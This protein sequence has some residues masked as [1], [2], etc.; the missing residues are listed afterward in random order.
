MN[1]ANL[2]SWNV[3]E[4]ISE[5]LR[6]ILQPVPLLAGLTGAGLLALYLLSFFGVLEPIGWPLLA[7][8]GIVLAM[9]AAH[10]GIVRVARRS[11]GLVAYGLYAMATAAAALGL[12]LVWQGIALVAA[13]LA[14]LAPGT[15]TRA[16]IP[17]NPL[18]AS[19]ALGLVATGAIF[20][21]DAHP[22]L[23]RMQ[24]GTTGG[25]AA[26]LL[27]ASMIAL[28]GLVTITTQAVRYETLQSR[29]VGSLVPIVAIPILF[30]TSISAFNALTTNQQ[31]FGSTLQAVSSLRKGQLDALQHTV[32]LELA[33]LQD[34]ATTASSIVHVI[35]RQNQSDEEYRLN[36][37]IAATQ[38]RD[39]IVTHP[40]SDYEEVMVM[41]L[42]GNVLLSTYLLDV[43]RNFADEAFFTRGVSRQGAVFT[44]FPGGQNPAGDYKLVAAAPVYASGQ[45]DVRGMVA[46]VANG[47]VVLNI[48][49]P[50]PG[51]ANANTYLV[52]ST[53]RPITPMQV[54][55]SLVGTPAIRNAVAQQQGQGSGLYINYAGVPV[56]GFYEWIPS[57][58]AAIVA[59]IP[60]ADLLSR[61][62]GALLASAFVGLLTIIIAVVAITTTSRSISE[63]VSDLAGVAEHLATGHLTTRAV[64]NREDE[65]GQLA[66]SFNSMAAQ[67]QGVI[68]DLERRVAERTR[69]LEQQTVRLRTAAE[70]AR[71]ATIATSLQDLLSRAAEF[72][73]ERFHLDHV[74]IF[75]LDEPKRFAVLQAS[76]TEVGRRMLEA[77]YRTPMGEA[78][79]VGQAASLGEAILAQ[80]GPGQTLQ[81]GDQFN[82]DTESQLALPLK[83]NIGLLG[84]L[85][86]QSTV[87]GAFM[88]SDPAIMQ[89][90][91]DQLAGAIERSRLLLQVQQRLGQLEETYRTFTEQAW[92]V[93]G[94]RPQATIGYRFDNVR[95]D[96]LNAVPPEV[97]QA[98][99][100]RDDG[101]GFDPADGDGKPGTLSVPIR[102]RGR[103]LGAVSVHL[104]P[105]ADP[106][107]AAG[108]VAEITEMLGTSLENVR[109]LEDSVHRARRERLIGDITSRIGASINMR[110]VLQTA[111]EELG[112]ALP[113][114]EVTIKFRE[115][116]P[117]AEQESPS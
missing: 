68:T 30:T 6:I 44:R 113:G 51:L 46:V 67:L 21:M 10:L 98:L 20:W 24:S 100:G 107:A 117:N 58:N 114:S 52:D 36:S 9:A 106:Q 62:L 1:Q 78:T 61:T 56:I 76:P 33:P 88:P 17:R 86:L 77:G 35:D 91:A 94:R 41:D 96:P 115:L 101:N 54:A 53:F 45:T 43:G 18:I 22:I 99:A 74:A 104:R 47:D 111:V 110:N 23:P 75:L 38:I 73:L 108:V 32:Y 25:F 3:E 59:E 48:I 50:T 97:E 109:L 2:E 92:T 14:W 49:G 112:H 64:T 34:G 37:S 71:D 13:L 80:K 65:I 42:Q 85:D 87:P 90:L 16:R 102:L 81:P 15:T 55:S 70:V 83:S 82:P 31:Q 29:L 28:F 89:V 72:I 26:V 93:Y 40:T 103:T 11:Q 105:G 60:Q 27:L 69:D 95:L 116:G 66:G 19:I 84:V 39:F 4:K 12:V 5:Y 79:A 57:V 8:S 7:A 63:P